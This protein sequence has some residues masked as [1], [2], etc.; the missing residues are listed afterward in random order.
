MLG[1]ASSAAREPGLKETGTQ[2]H[3]LWALG[4][5]ARPGD[6][7]KT[8]RKLRGRAKDEDAAPSRC[9]ATGH[10]LGSSRKDTRRVTAHAGAPAS[11]GSS[12]TPAQHLEPGIV[13]KSLQGQL[14]PCRGFA[15]TPQCPAPCLKRAASLPRRLRL[16]KHE[17]FK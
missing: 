12:W 13:W 5:P 2:G 10:F 7:A 15:H 4:A 9:P 16:A 14:I 17:C 1:R 11:P 8:H 6:S 3:R